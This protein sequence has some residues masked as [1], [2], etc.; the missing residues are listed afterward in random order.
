MFKL[1]LQL[2]F[3]CKDEN[4]QGYGYVVGGHVRVSDPGNNEVWKYDP[5]DDV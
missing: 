2:P 1:V 3:K 5:A 4:D